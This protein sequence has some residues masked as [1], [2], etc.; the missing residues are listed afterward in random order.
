MP[1]ILVTTV[2]GGYN[3]GAVIEMQLNGSVVFTATG[4]SPYN[5]NYD[6]T[7]GSFN[8]ESGSVSVNVTPPPDSSGVLII[9]LSGAVSKTMSINHLGSNT[10]YGYNFRDS[11]IIGGGDLP[12]YDDSSP[13]FRI[14]FTDGSFIT[15]INE[16]DPPAY[17]A[18]D[19]TFGIPNFMFGSFE[20]L[21]DTVTRYDYAGNKWEISEA[22]AVINDQIDLRS[23]GLR[24][25]LGYSPQSKILF[26]SIPAAQ[27]LPFLST[28]DSQLNAVLYDGNTGSSGYPTIGDVIAA[29]ID[30]YYDGGLY[31]VNNILPI[32]NENNLPVH[33]VTVFGAHHTTTNTVDSYLV[34][35][36]GNTRTINIDL[37]Q[38]LSNYDPYIGGDSDPYSPGGDTG[39]DETG[40]TGGTGDFDGT[41]DDV[42]IP[43]LP[44]L[45]ATDTGFITLFNPS[46]T[47]LRNLAAYM[48]SSGFD[49]DTFKKIFADPMNCILGLSIVPVAVPSGGARNVSVGNISTGVTMTLA[50]SQY[51]EVDCGTLNVNEFWG[52]YLDYDPYTKAEIYLPYIGAHPLAVDDIMGKA[53][54]VV[55]HVDIL[56]G[57]CCAY[58]KCDGSV[59]YS[60]IGQ[61]ASSIPITGNDWTNVINGVL[62][63]AGA[64]GSMVATGGAAA[65][66]AAG[67]IASTAVNGFKP[68]IEKSG[69]MS[70][71]GGMMG[72]QTPYL[73][74][75][76]PRQALP[77]R[78]NTFIGYP[79][80][81]TKTLSSISGYTEVESVHLEGIHATE[82]ELTEIESLLKTGVIF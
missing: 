46:A 50:A 81:I 12:T 7:T 28:T 63:V 67:I 74:L 64:I 35:N 59:L 34:T 43:N 2:S 9:A 3:G 18:G 11:T 39:D 80:F 77:K 75:T 45:S 49:L 36:G 24:S 21:S 30:K 32:D 55:Y 15:M 53:V 31:N 23:G 44:S 37:T 26:L 29:G 33:G 61:C 56:S 57:A 14:M 76:R 40:G 62:S 48:W 5:L 73:I 69:S 22:G 65:P 41:G 60:F 54:H 16:L 82:Q 70:G 4:D 42:D 10:S 27:S 51:V 20:S 8:T 78:Q 47:Q 68:N 19:N 38:S 6:V 52:A 66:M 79:S 25:W 71:T 1:Q 17:G 13:M 58:V 72:I